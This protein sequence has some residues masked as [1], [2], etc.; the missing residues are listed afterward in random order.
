M[1]TEPRIVLMDANNQEPLRKWRATQTKEFGLPI[2]ATALVSG[3]KYKIV[4]AGDT[5]FTAIGAADSNVGTIF[6]ATGAG[7][8]TGTAIQMV[9]RYNVKSGEE[10]DKHTFMIWNNRKS[11]EVIDLELK[12]GCSTNGSITIKLDAVDYTIDVTANNDTDLLALAIEEALNLNSGFTA[13]WSIQIIPAVT[14]DGVK[15]KNTIISFKAKD[16]VE[17]KE[18]QF[19][20]NL[21]GIDAVMTQMIK[22][23][24]ATDV[25]SKITDA[26]VYIR[27]AEGGT[28]SDVIKKKWAFMKNESDSSYVNLGV[29]V[30]EG[31]GTTTEY[32][33]KLKAVSSEVAVGEILGAVNTGSLEDTKNYDKVS[34][35]MKPP[36]EGVAQGLRPWKLV[37]TYNFT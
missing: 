22:G 11:N 29:D 6:V 10:S 19:T 9:K 4:T 1:G 14:F 32:E 28:T 30:D 8:G 7:T 24:A 5:D 20:A 36:A 21:S 15:I 16:F 12:S 3:T 31:L 13:A 27:D 35:Y 33:L 18:F 2:D 25:V 37:I 26:K 17:K 23:N 34:L